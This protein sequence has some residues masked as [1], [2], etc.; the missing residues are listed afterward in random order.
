MTITEMSAALLILMVDSILDDSLAFFFFPSLYASCSA[1]VNDKLLSSRFT[2][3]GTQ[4][5]AAAFPLT[6]LPS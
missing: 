1:Q 4:A 6:T 2:C 5:E 3:L